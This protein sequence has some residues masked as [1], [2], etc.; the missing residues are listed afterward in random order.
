MAGTTS[1]DSTALRWRWGIFAGGAI[2]LLFL[3]SALS[4]LFG[5]IIFAIC[6]AAAA[7]PIAHIIERKFSRAVS[8]ALSLG[9]LLT[10]VLGF[11]GLFLPLLLS[12]FSLLMQQLPRL[13]SLLQAFWHQISQT[14]WIQGL[15][16]EAAIPQNWLGQALGHLAQQLPGVI[17]KIGAIVELI[18]RAFLAPVLAFYFLRDRET[19]SYQLSLCI[20]AQYRKQALAALQEMRRE[21]GGYI[22]G[23]LLISL[24]VAALTAAG[25]LLAGVPAWLA[26]GILMGVCELV[27]YIGPIIGTIPIALFSLPLGMKT[28]LWGLGIAIGVQQIEGFFLSPHLMAGATGLHPVSIILLLSAGA[29]LFGFMGMVIALPLFVCIRGAARAFYAHRPPPRL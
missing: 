28:F 9:I 24:S 16:L 7:L 18:S 15:H 1:S 19:F 10:V 25:L 5:Q 21:A 20:P 2:L 23:Q 6:L 27:P 3:W 22:R 12:Q 8:T 11:I 14:E 4:Q 17:S 29:L 13:L 26:L